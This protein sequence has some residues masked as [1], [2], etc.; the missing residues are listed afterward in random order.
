MSARDYGAIMRE[1]HEAFN[2]RDLDRIAAYATEDARMVIV[3]TGETFRGPEGYKRYMQDWVDAFSE[4]STEVTAVHAGESFAIVEYIGRGTHDG[5]LTS[6]AGE[7]P[8]T[9]RSLE[10]RHCEVFDMRDGK[11]T[12]AR[13]YFDLA[14]MMTQFSLIPAPEGAE[15]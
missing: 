2:A 1:G 9:G 8:P 5:T 13:S 14:G 15:A 3:P 7:V 6:P 11:I 4:A 10:T 12:G